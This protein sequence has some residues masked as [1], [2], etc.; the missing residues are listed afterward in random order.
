MTLLAGQPDALDPR[1]PL[2]AAHG[3]NCAIDL[4]FELLCRSEGLERERD[5]GMPGIGRLARLL[6]EIDDVAPER[7]RIEHP[8]EKPDDQAQAIA[9]VIPDRKKKAFIG[10]PGIG[11]RLAVA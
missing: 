5:N 6:D 4:V 1:Q 3:A 2:G 7:R 8:R 10:T 11:E 9:L